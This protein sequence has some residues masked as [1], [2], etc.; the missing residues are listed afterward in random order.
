MWVLLGKLHS[1][2]I[3][4][5]ECEALTTDFT[6]RG[7]VHSGQRHQRDHQNDHSKPDFDAVT[8]A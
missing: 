1:C 3:G 6:L 5:A 7:L 8:L 4:E 2:G